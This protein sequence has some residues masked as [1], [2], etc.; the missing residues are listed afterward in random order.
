MSLSVPPLP[1]KQAPHS[2]C[3]ACQAAA[4]IQIPTGTQFDPVY[5]L[6]DAAG[7][8]AD[9]CEKIDHLEEFMTIARQANIDVLKWT[10]EYAAERELELEPAV[11][12][13]RKELAARQFYIAD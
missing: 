2:L 10:I 8:F 13:R 7:R 3:G 5:R 4:N 11:Q 1:E 12:A 9:A 6:A